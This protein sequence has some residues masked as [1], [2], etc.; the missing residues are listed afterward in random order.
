MR[1]TRDAYERRFQQRAVDQ[2]TQKNYQQ[3]IRAETMD[4]IHQ[5][6]DA[7]AAM[8]QKG[9]RQRVAD[10][11][12]EYAEKIW[13][14]QHHQ[15]LMQ[16]EHDDQDA[17]AKALHDQIQAETRDEKRRGVLRGNDP[18]YRELKAK[19]HLA[20]ISQIRDNQRRERSM[21]RKLD[22][23]E[24]LETETEM[25]RQYQR[26]EQARA[27]E[28]EAKHR[29]SLLAGRVIQEQMRD[30][31]RR[32]QLIEAADANRDRD[33]VEAVVKRIAEEDAAVQRAY[34][35]RQDHERQ[36]M[37]DFM[38]ARA[39]MREEERALEEDDDKRMKAFNVA[40]DERL[41]RAIADQKR[42][43]ANRA[44]IAQK[45]ALDIKQK[46]DEAED[47]ENLCLELARQQEIQKLND[48]AVA[49]ARAIAERHEEMRRF[50]IET[51]IAKAARIARDAE[52]EKILRR[53]VIEQTKRMEE[54][55]IIE[56]QKNQLRIERYKRELAWQLVQKKSMYED[57]RQEELRKLQVEQ[58]REAE[59]QR[60][61]EEERR[62]LV[63][64]HVL[65][66]GPESVQYLPKGVLKESD[67]DHLP[68]DYRNAILRLR[69][70]SQA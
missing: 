62:K 16:R 61:L 67:L 7:R 12:F 28:E 27:A 50:M 40:I 64:T 46:R 11:E 59:N 6:T 36:E 42:R 5:E 34:R 44:K 10:Q 54:L 24:R 26:Q 22:E 57:A 39:R 3:K 58:D 41:E 31:E 63:I 66:M 23:E 56:Q 60:I 2:F 48:R 30:K 52:E 53:Q 68:E 15:E 19:L 70:E 47:Y 32:R 49:E 21:R 4:R 18:E 45:I 35:E 13:Q 43:E 33:Q 8:R 1:V 65:A 9:S 25:M 29:E 69:I 37:Y 51:Q 20:V 55:A 38:A 17:I 14:Q